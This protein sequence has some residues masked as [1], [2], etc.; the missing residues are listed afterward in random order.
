V[1]TVRDLTDSKYAQSGTQHQVSRN[2]KTTSLR[3]MI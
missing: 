1:F 3:K 2:H